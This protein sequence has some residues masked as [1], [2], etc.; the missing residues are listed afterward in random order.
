[1][2]RSAGLWLLLP[3]EALPLLLIGGA[4]LVMF[5]VAS[6]R[7]VLGAVV[8]V[9]LIPVFSPI[10]EALFAALPAWVALLFCVGMGFWCL[11]AIAATV[12]G[13]GAA[14][15]MV[16]SLAADLVRLLVKTAFVPV[17]LLWR[18]ISR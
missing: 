11:Q 12:I 8:F 16:G 13:R 2:G 14:E 3:Q 18:L 7:A 4:F 10:I 17:R 1:M 5:R 15:H 9:V 6:F